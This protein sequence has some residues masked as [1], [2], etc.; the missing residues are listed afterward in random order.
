MELW[1]YIL[2]GIP[3]QALTDEALLTPNYD[4]SE[5][6]EDPFNQLEFICLAMIVAKREELLDSDFSMCLGTF[7]KY[8]EP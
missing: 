4:L 1:D 8:D 2:A 3:I 5:L 6:P 7:M